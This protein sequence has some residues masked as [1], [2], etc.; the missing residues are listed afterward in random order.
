MNLPA[1]GV[2]MSKWE[3]FAV[4]GALLL[5]Y[6]CATLLSYRVHQLELRIESVA[7]AVEFNRSREKAQD[8]PGF[9]PETDWQY[10]KGAACGAYST[11][12]APA[13]DWIMVIPK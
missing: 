6:A 2:S 5:S 10:C 8:L 1:E 13:D 11:I 3:S 7:R 12:H 9:N 4:G